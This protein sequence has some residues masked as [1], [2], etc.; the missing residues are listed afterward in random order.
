MDAITADAFLTSSG[1]FSDPTSISAKVM[2]CSEIR[3]ASGRMEKVYFLYLLWTDFLF[4]VNIF[5]FCELIYKVVCINIKI[6]AR[7]H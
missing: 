2:S 1:E 4:F 3:N 6:A 7:C 5:L